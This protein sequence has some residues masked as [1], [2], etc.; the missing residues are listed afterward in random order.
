MCRLHIFTTH[1]H[2]TYL[3]SFSLY[4]TPRSRAKALDTSL[5][6]NSKI[7]LAPSLVLEVQSKIPSYCT[8]TGLCISR[9]NTR[10]SLRHF[11][12][13]GLLRMHGEAKY[14][15]TVSRVFLKVCLVIFSSFTMISFVSGMLGIEYNSHTLEC[16]QK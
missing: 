16:K 8:Y 3:M 5:L 14:S 12:R 1:T 4:L 7:I 15:F 13:S 9:S 6:L 11:R 10:V 2:L